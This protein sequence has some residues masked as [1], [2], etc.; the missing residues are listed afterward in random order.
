MIGMFYMSMF[1]KKLRKN[2]KIK[3]ILTDE[4]RISNGTNLYYDNFFKK[5]NKYQQYMSLK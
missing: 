1:M 3:W 4:F 2:T 5:N